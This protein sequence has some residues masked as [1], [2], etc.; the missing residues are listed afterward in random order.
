MGLPSVVYNA[1]QIPLNYDQR[2]Y[3]VSQRTRATKWAG[4]QFVHHYSSRYDTVNHCRHA[5]HLP[6]A[7]SKRT[8]QEDDLSTPAEGNGISVQPYDDMN[9]VK[10]THSHSSNSNTEEAEG[11]ESYVSSVRTVALWVC[12]AV[13]F[14]VGLGLKDG[15]GKATEFF[16]GYLLEQSLSVDNLFVFV[17][18]FKYFKVPTMYQ[19][20]VLSYGIAGAVVFRLTL[21]LLGTAT[22]L[23][24]EAVNLLLAVILLYS[25]FKL[26]ASEDNETDLSNNFLVKTCQKF[27]PVTTYYDGNRFITNQDGLW[28]ATPLLLTVAVIELSDIAFAVDSIPAVFGVTRDPFIVFTSNLFAILGLRSLYK[29]ISEGMS[30]LEY[31]QPSIAVVLGFIGFKMISGLFW[32]VYCILSSI[33]VL[34]LIFFT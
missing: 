14:G 2:L 9:R 13:A 22:L 28:K 1:V 34:I 24:F 5:Q 26:F 20:R 10:S 33:Y 18:I 16:A 30:E 21:I 32:S 23:R 25:S 7:C 3:R 12:T 8:D 19:N 15:V 6:T 11:H 31:L 27:V 29:L 17:L 4:L